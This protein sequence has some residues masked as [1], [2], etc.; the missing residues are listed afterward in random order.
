LPNA[1]GS[2]GALLKNRPL[3]RETST[4]LFIRNNLPGTSPYQP[5]EQGTRNVEGWTGKKKNMVAL[6]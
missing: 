4:K 5:F 2:Q 6:K 3:V 1:S